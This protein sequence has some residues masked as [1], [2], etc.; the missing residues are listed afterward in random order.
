MRWSFDDVRFN[1][2][3][4][5]PAIVQE[6]TTHAVLMLAWMDA[7]ALRRTL[8]TGRA[9][10]WSRS[11]QQHWVKGET[12]GITSTSARSG[13][14]ATETRFCS[15]STRPARPATPAPTPAS[16]TARSSRSSQWRRQRMREWLAS[17]GG[18]AVTIVVGLAASGVCALGVARP[19]VRATATVQGLPP[20]AASVDGADVAPVAAALG[21]RLPGR[22]RRRAGDTGLGAQS[23][24]VLIAACAATV[25]VIAAVAVVDDRTARGR[26]VGARLDWRRLRPNGHR[27]ALAVSL[28]AS[29]GARG[30]GWSPGS[31]ASGRRWGTRYDAPSERQ[32]VDAPRCR[33]ADVGGRRVARYR[34]TE[35]TRRT[36]R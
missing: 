26:V 30:C 28:P 13:S 27:L 8:A 33:R 20:I 3:G 1:D 2:Q 12:S 5:V 31:P 15:S 19:W 21:R 4:L 32:T 14:T 29:C 9:T 7:E 18:Y 35:T 16:T 22:L 6:A 36:D 23:A 17:R 10:Y 11:R 25:V 24:R 34:P